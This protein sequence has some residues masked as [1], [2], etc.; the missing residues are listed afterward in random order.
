VPRALSYT[1]SVTDDPEGDDAARPAGRRRG[2]S[3]QLYDQAIVLVA[4]ERK[5]CVSLSSATCRSAITAPP[6]SS[7]AWRRRAVTAANHV[8]GREI[9]A[10]DIEDRTR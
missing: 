2:R 5:W 6:A 10:R 1:E 8:G 7:S 4:R 3:H 9:L